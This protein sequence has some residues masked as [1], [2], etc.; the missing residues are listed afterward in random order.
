MIEYNWQIES[1]SFI[2]DIYIF[3]SMLNKKK[4]NTQRKKIKKQ[5]HITRYNITCDDEPLNRKY[6]CGILLEYVNVIA[7][8]VIS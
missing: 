3:N 5:Q 4:K 7:N 8:I 2:Q 6:I 1:K